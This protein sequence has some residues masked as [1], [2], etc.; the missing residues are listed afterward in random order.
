M[1]KLL[2]L[3]LVLSMLLTLCACGEEN[4][5][6]ESPEETYYW[7][8]EAVCRY[9]FGLDGTISAAAADGEHI[10]LCGVRDGT[11]CLARMDYTLDGGL[12]IGEA[13]VTALPGTGSPISLDCA[14]GRFLLLCSEEADGTVQYTV[15]AYLPDGSL[16]GTYPVSIDA[17]DE[18]RSILALPDGGFWLRGV[19]N[20]RRYSASGE[21]LEIFTRE[22][23]EFCPPLLIGGEAVFQTIDTDSHR[24]KL[25][26]YDAAGKLIPID[27]DI[28]LRAPSAVCRSAAGEALMC[29]GGTLLSIDSDF[30]AERTVELDEL[31]SVQ[32]Q[33]EEVLS[34]DENT[35][36]FV[37]GK[38]ETIPPENSGELICLTRE[39]TIDNRRTVNIAF[40]GRASGMLA[41]LKAQYTQLS[42]DH[43]VE[44][45]DYGADEEGLARLLRDIST[46]EGI[47]LIVSD[48]YSIDTA[49]GF[50]DLYPFLDA[51][52]KLSR[53]SFVP[54][55]PGIERNGRLSEIWSG[56]SICT[57]VSDGALRDKPGA[58][59]LAECQAYLDTIGCTEPLFNGWMTKTELLRCMT[60]GIFARGTAELGSDGVR[61]LLEMCS[62]RPA[63]VNTEETE[64]PEL[65]YTDLQ[66]D[67]LNRAMESGR[68]LRLLDGRDGGDDFTSLV[69]D[70]RGCYMIPETCP[71]KENAW[72]FLRLLLM[73][74]QQL[75]D[76]D[77]RRICYP[78]NA[79]ALNAVLDSYALPELG[80]TVMALID[81]APVYTQEIAG[82]ERIFIESMQ[83]YLYGDSDMDTALSIAR[84]KLEIFAAEHS[85]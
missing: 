46:G 12:R 21:E 3:M 16:T 78:S 53:E 5:E 57:F 8:T 4:A 74:G 1:K 63:E 31:Y 22:R 18:A 73:E 81:G 58:L 60:P 14:A 72:S 39:W 84:G 42:P 19:H 48:G 69:C 54:G 34:L 11:P 29:M 66:P 59:R 85:A 33:Y 32:A 27:C 45:L 64:S 10:F 25:N 75:K 67:Y 37:P 61:A 24:S 28:D 23:V 83:P 56:F 76:F 79:A 15:S 71:D 17:G 26:R 68:A 49:V 82:M 36:L 20:I 52:P 47:D 7:R 65:M 70:P 44:C 2:T 13:A 6:P 43:R 41:A 9:P 38:A 40:Y 80:G 62:A 51:D 35:Y 30:T 77:R 55:L 50:T